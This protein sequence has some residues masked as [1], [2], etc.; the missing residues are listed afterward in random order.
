MKTR[1]SKLDAFAP[2]LD[3][4]FTAGKTLEEAQGV[5]KGRGC[6]VSLS[7]LSDWWSDRQTKRMQERLLGQIASG[8]RQCKEVE[9]ALGKNGAPELDTLIKLHRVLILK[10]STEVN[11][12]PET[13]EIVAQMMKPVMDYAKLE[14][15]RRELA[16]SEQ[17]YRDQVRAN[18]EALQRELKKA[19]AEGGISNETFEFVEQKLKLF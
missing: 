6:S 14:E 8:S 16:L 1:P 3:E 13:I 10:L 4:L 2:E 19:K 9:A 7:R 12:K 15:K 18:S 17:K 11:T 5:L